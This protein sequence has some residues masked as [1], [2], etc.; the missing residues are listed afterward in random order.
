VLNAAQPLSIQLHPDKATAEAGFAAENALDIPVSS[1]HRNYV[2]SNHKPEL[3]CALTPFRALCGFRPVEDICASLALIDP[4]QLRHEVTQLQEKG[5]SAALESL[6]LKLLQLSEDDARAMLDHVLERA[7][8]IEHDNARALLAIHEFYPGDRG[9]LFALLLN[10][11]ELAPGEAMF[12][13]AG[14]LHSYLSG[15]GLE[16][17]ASSDNVIRGGLTGKHVD[18]DELMKL[19]TFDTLPEAQLRVAP[20]VRGK[21]T[22]Y[23]TPAEDFTL[24]LLQV[25]TAADRYTMSSAEIVL[26]LSGGVTVDAG[27]RSVVLAPGE[28]CFIGAA[29]GTFELSGAGQVARAAVDIP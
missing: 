23:P 22:I 13:A 14:H 2:D 25:D 19:T 15:A 21:Q 29:A 18:C 8:H 26:C 9:V 24:A 27:E 16:I 17:M 10:L 6:C 3:I 5:D 20:V 1:P 7:A 12:L 28:A 4:P 11:V